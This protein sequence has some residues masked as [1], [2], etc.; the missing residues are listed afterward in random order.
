MNAANPV[1]PADAM[2]NA[3]RNKSRVDITGS[4]SDR[5]ARASE[6]IDAL[7]KKPAGAEDRDKDR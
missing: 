4:S 6:Q 2:L 7:L 1:S 5:I 3:G